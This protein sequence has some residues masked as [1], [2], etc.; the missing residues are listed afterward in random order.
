M[1][2]VWFDYERLAPTNDLA[3]QTPSLVLILWTDLV[4]GST[5]A[6]SRLSSVM[7]PCMSDKVDACYKELTY[8]LDGLKDLLL[9]VELS[10]RL[11]VWSISSKSLVKND[12]AYSR[13]SRPQS[14]S[15]LLADCPLVEGQTRHL[16]PCRLWR[17]HIEAWR[18]T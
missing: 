11:S 9:G 5:H 18:T 7:K 4:S 15:S 3:L 8:R 2:L 6:A 17:K 14:R 10:L 1:D 13:I 16:P 12:I